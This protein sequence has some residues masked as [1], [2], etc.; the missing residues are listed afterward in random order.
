[1]TY[2]STGLVN[3]GQTDH[4]HIVYDDSLSPA[5]GRDRAIALQK[6]CEKDFTLMQEWFG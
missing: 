1:M 5:D 3:L 4:Y 6:E 2:I